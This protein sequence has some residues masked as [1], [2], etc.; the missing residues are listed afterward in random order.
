MSATASPRWAARC[1]RCDRFEGVESRPGHAQRVLCDRC[2]ESP[3]R[4]ISASGLEFG[5]GDVTAKHRRDS[6]P[7]CAPESFETER[8]DVFRLLPEA[9]PLDLPAHREELEGESGA[10]AEP[11]IPA[12][13]SSSWRPVPLAAVLADDEV[14]PP[15][16]FLA[17][18]DGRA[19][20]YRGRIHSVSGE[21]ESCKGWIALAACTERFLAGQR[22]LYVDFEDTAPS[23]VARLLALG[24]CAEAIRDRFV[25]L[26]PDQPLD[27]RARRYLQE[28]AVDVTLVVLDGVTESLAQQGLNLESNSDI[29]AWLELLPRPLARAGAAVVLLDHVVKDR[30]QR[31]RYAIGAQH[32]LAGIDAAYTVKVITPFGRGREGKVKLTVAKDRPGHVRGFAVE[33]KDAAVIRL[34]SDEDGAVRVVVEPPDAA[35]PPAFRPTTLIEKLSK[36][37]EAEPGLTTNGVIEAVGGKKD[38]KREALR[39]LVDEGYIE[40]RRDGQAV[41][42]HPLREYRAA[43]DEGQ[44]SPWVPTGSRPGPGAVV[45]HRVP[46]SPPTGPGTR[47]PVEGKG[48]PSPWIPPK[49]AEW[50][51]RTLTGRSG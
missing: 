30:E 42:H 50:P 6:P 38:A 28:A 2:A 19:L 36:A 45:G 9:D 15:P 4:P 18:T 35:A 25:Y 8:D 1:T 23:I 11:G 46:G 13:G 22:V 37:V 33:R 34:I 39:L 17:R 51:T 10:S 27:E 21:P 43:N 24:A 47:G 31:G 3:P 20:L 32:K 12:G 14:D 48:Q 5:A 16:V 41:R 49:P 40:Q 7:D 26:R 44:T 29:A